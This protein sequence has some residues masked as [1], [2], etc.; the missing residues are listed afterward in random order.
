LTK[1]ELLVKENG[2]IVSREDVVREVLKGL[3]GIMER[4]MSE[5]DFKIF[6]EE[7]DARKAKNPI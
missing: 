2:D 1:R 5:E 3:I 4:G 7:L 6:R